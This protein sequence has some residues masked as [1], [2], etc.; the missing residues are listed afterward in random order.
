MFPFVQNLILLEARAEPVPELGFS[1]FNTIRISRLSS[2]LTHTRQS[3]SPA[4]CDAMGFFRPEAFSPE[5]SRVH[6]VSVP[7][8]LFPSP[9]A[10]FNAAKLLSNRGATTTFP[11]DHGHLVRISKLRICPVS[12]FESES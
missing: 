7:V 6:R 1:V 5:L 10:R 3:D 12:R 11:C 4:D 2:F 8:A 9:P